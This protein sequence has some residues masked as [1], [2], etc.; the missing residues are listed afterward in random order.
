MIK[1][2]TENSPA[3]CAATHGN[4]TKDN[5][6]LL[7][8]KS[9]YG[10][11]LGASDG[12]IGHLKDFYFD[13]QT[14]AIR[15]LVADTG[16]WLPGRQVLLSPHTLGRCDDE[17][18]ILHVGLSRKKIEHS[19]S[20]ETHMPVSRQYEEEYYQY[21]GWPTYWQGDGLWGVSAFPVREMPPKPHPS[22]RSSKK[23][24]AAVHLRSTLEVTGYHIHASDG[25]FG[26][27]EDF[28]VDAH[29]W[30]IRQLVVRTGF[31]LTRHEV[32]VPTATVNRISYEESTMFTSLSK[33]AIEHSPE[34]HLASH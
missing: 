14:W 26:H 13:D 29:S 34:H 27:V 2:N 21:Y 19:P 17:E 4:Q 5:N 10:H 1:H 12:N 16:H 9:L 25:E 32:Q 11:K 33:K 28:L 31:L 20:I 23:G 7:S 6:M 15:Y 24:H 18:K 8:I 30:A 22:D 3:K